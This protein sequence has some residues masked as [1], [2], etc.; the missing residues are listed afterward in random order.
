ANMAIVLSAAFLHDIGIKEAEKKHQSTAARYQEEY[1]PPIARG[2]LLKL[3]AETKLIEEVC[4]IVGH[5]HHP[6]ENE[7]VNFKCLYDAD[8][9]TNLEEQQK[10]KLKTSEH[11]D[12]IIEKSFL[13]QSGRD[14]AK[15]ILI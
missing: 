14:L 7:T 3:S 6:R 13:T 10:E 12:K 15:K 11:I 5:H 8:L 2:I 4:D 1:G 9:I